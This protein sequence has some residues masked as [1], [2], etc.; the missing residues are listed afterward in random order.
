MRWQASAPQASTSSVALYS[1]RHPDVDN[2][3]HPSRPTNTWPSSSSTQRCVRAAA[4]PLHVFALRHAPR[5][6]LDVAVLLPDDLLRASVHAAGLALGKLVFTIMSFVGL[7]IIYGTFTA[8]VVGLIGDACSNGNNAC[9]LSA[10]RRSCPWRRMAATVRDELKKEEKKEEA[11]EG[12]R[13]I[14]IAS[15]P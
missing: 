1:G 12:C 15:M 14:F 13:R 7:T 10:A 9:G 4:P 5:R 2:S 3:T 6:L 11:T 8:F